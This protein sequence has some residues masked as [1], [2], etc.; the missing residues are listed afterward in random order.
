MLS[1]HL[2]PIFGLFRR[3][4]FIAYR[5][6]RVAAFVILA[7]APAYAFECAAPIIPDWEGNLR[8]ATIVA[9]YRVERLRPTKDPDTKIATVLITRGWKGAKAGDRIEIALDIPKIG[10]TTRQQSLFRA[11]DGKYYLAH[12]LAVHSPQVLER[13]AKER[14][15]LEVKAKAAPDDIDAQI[16]LISHYNYW[17]EHQLA[18]SALE[19]LIRTTPENGRLQFEYALALVGKG[20]FDAAR[21]A[22]DKAYED[23][24]LRSRVGLL[25]MKVSA[26]EALSGAKGVNGRSFEMS[27]YSTIAMASLAGENVSKTILENLQ[28]LGSLDARD[29]DWTGSRIINV[30]FDQSNFSGAH[31]S[32]VFFR[33]V[34]FNGASLFRAEAR[35]TAFDFSQFSGADL[36]ELIAPGASFVRAY[37]QRADLTR[38]DLT[39]ANFSEADLSGAALDEA[40]L[41]GADLSR[42]ILSNATWT[43]ASLKDARLIG[44][45]LRGVDLTRANIA[46]AD[47]TSARVDCGTRFPN[48]FDRTSVLLVP[49]ARCDGQAP[50][51]LGKTDLRRLPRRPDFA[52]AYL[53]G[54]NFRNLS[55]P[56]NFSGANLD[57]ANFS[58]SSSARIRLSGVSARSASFEEISGEIDIGNSDLTAARITGRGDGSPILRIDRVNVRL[59]K[60]DLSKV[61]IDVWSGLWNRPRPEFG[62]SLQQT[63]VEESLIKCRGAKPDSAVVES[64]AEKERHRRELISEFI[65]QLDL[66]RQLAALHPSNKLE[67]GCAKAIDLYLGGACK[68]GFAD[69]GFA[70]ACPPAP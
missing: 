43:G 31:L 13:F 59:D 35:N 41:D 26:L 68:A 52:M 45:D 56:L 25:E 17:E 9:D 51:D 28:M 57:G 39:S 3:K 49:M 47:L 29:S 24:S 32:G 20:K 7:S 5:I 23:K 27:R 64:A 65:L 37:L 14:E 12:C 63:R 46:G 30:G 8:R 1:H 44:A 60:A 18:L 2:G 58:G 33:K 55:A 50:F 19:R 36:H 10:S 67:E 54:A 40:R 11:K 38:A 61:V 34:S 42:A 53:A 70:Y 69:A 48:S 22:M 4:R 16:D 15:A 62:T 66:A 21:V 6:V